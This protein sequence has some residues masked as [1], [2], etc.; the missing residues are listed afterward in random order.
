MASATFTVTQAGK[1]VVT[2]RK[3]LFLM[4]SNS[5]SIQPGTYDINVTSNGTTKNFKGSYLGN[6]NGGGTAWMM[7]TNIDGPNRDNC[8]WPVAVME[9]GGGITCSGTISG[10]VVSRLAMLDSEIGGYIIGTVSK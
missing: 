7:M 8:Y 3:Q 9:V 10:G 4:T 6:N 5:I 2:E 1:S